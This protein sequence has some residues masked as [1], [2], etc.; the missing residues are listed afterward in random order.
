MLLASRWLQIFP[1]ELMFKQLMVRTF[2]LQH[3]Y[4]RKAKQHNDKERC[5]P[6]Y[7]AFYSED[8]AKYIQPAEKQR[9]EW[10]FKYCRAKLNLTHIV[11]DVAQLFLNARFRY[12]E[13]CMTKY[14]ICLFIHH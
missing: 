13:Y 9:K 8:E 3:L 14:P 12:Q 4:A 7:F 6:T 5:I 1:W 10:L 11:S 2:S